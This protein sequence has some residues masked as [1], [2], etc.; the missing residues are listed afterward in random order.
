MAVKKKKNQHSAAWLQA[1]QHDEQGEEAIKH[2]AGK[3][4]EI[5]KFKLFLHRGINIM[6]KFLCPCNTV[7]MHF[8]HHNHMK[9]CFSG[10]KARL[11]RL[12]LKNA[13]TIYLQST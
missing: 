12:L 3:K 13:I 6:H 8:T 7:C 1:W 9:A 11:N 5:C 2:W 10:W 4:E